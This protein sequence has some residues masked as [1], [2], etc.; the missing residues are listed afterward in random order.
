MYAETREILGALCQILL[1]LMIC[2][3]VPA[4]QK[5]I[6]E[7]QESELVVNVIVEG[8]NDDEEKNALIYLELEKNKHNPDLNELWLK[9]L[10]SRAPENIK[11]SL[12]PFGY[13]QVTVES[14]LEQDSTGVWQASYQVKPGQRVKVKK[15]DVQIS[16]GGANDSQI[17]A[18]V[19]K[20]PI[21][22]ND[23]LDHELYETEK[24]NLLSVIGN[25]G[26]SDVKTEKKRLL[27]DP[28]EN[29]A[30][31][32]LYIDTGEKYYLGQ[33]RFHQNT[34]QVDLVNRYLVDVEPGDPF[35]QKSLLAIQQ[36]LVSSG[37][38]S[39]V[40]IKPEYKETKDQHVPIDIT[41]TPAKRHKLSF[42]IGYDTEID[43]NAS[44]RW[45]NR[46]L[47]SYGHNTD[48]LLKVSDKKSSLRGTY[49]IPINDPRTDKIG[50][51]AKFETEETDDTDR[52]TLNLEAAWVF[53][54]RDWDSKLFT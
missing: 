43:L 9:R 50:F 6:A 37:Y 14:R 13:Y 11:H 2:Q 38:F 36:S 10:H 49:W 8:L 46:L 20:F 3:T 53:K 35:S 22:E 41:L 48:A 16:G 17:L 27:I 40:D 42:G 15:V 24:T 45:Q 47:N 18:A 12:R 33:F 5:N 32:T 4:Q 44:M 23:F 21:K 1:L 19:K 30:E 28:L 51:T 29:S 7:E 31:L 25:L 52:N 39:V 26:Y 34:L 54:W